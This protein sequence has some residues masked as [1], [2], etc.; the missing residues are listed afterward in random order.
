MKKTLQSLLLE[1]KAAVLERW[2][3]LV[4]DTYPADGARFFKQE[5]DKF[6]NPVGSTI[7]EGTAAI[8]AE[9]TGGKNVNILTNSLDSIIRIRAVQDF[10]PSGALA[11]IPLIKRAIREELDAEI[12]KNALFEELS[13]FESGI[14]DLM[15][16]GTDIFVICR[17]QISEIRYKEVSAQRDMAVKFLAGT[18]SEET[19]GQADFEVKP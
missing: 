19:V 1:N 17:E 12:K 5:K 9:L 13:K 10:S 3:N 8:Y 4:F 16:L 15:L 11:F 14:D 2:C 6:A 7:L 18:D